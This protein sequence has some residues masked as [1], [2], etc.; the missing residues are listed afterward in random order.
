MRNSE[1]KILNKNVSDYLLL[2]TNHLMNTRHC[3]HS[4]FHAFFQSGNLNIKVIQQNPLIAF[5]QLLQRY[6]QL[7]VPFA[8]DA[9]ARMYFLE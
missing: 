7:I 2:T 4:Y 1:F 6:D 9:V 8:R 5:Y 3:K